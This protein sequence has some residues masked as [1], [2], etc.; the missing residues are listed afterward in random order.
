MVKFVFLWCVPSVLTAALCFVPQATWQ[1][2]RDVSLG[3]RRTDRVPSLL[4]KCISLVVDHID[5]VESLFGL[6]E[7]VKVHVEK[8][9]GSRMGCARTNHGLE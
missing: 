2:S 9:T 3:A 4:S 6:P 7:A 8:G 1:P 5:D